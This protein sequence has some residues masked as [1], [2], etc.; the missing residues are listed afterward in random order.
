MVDAKIKEQQ[1]MSDIESKVFKHI[2]NPA[3][4]YTN[5][6]Q[7]RI[8]LHH[9]SEFSELSKNGRKNMDKGIIACLFYNWTGAKIPVTTFLKQYYNVFCTDK[10]FISLRA[11]L[12][13]QIVTLLTIRPYIQLSI[14]K[15][16]K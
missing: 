12:V 14:L 4:R 5:A 10:N 7:A 3:E 1:G 11:H 16:Q 6:M 15:L 2:E 13:L 9:L 8:L